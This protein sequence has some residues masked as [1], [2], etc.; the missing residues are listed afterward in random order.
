MGI[1]RVFIAR[2]RRLRTLPPVVAGQRWRYTGGLALLLWLALNVVAAE[3]KRV[4]MI[5]SFGATAPP[6]T[7]HSTAFEEELT[8]QAGQEVDLDEVSL[9]MA[10]YTAPDL[11]DAFA[12]FL[13]TRL[14]K[15]KPDLV[16]PIGSPA[17]RFVAQHRGRLFPQTSILYA[18]MD[19]RTLPPDALQTNAAF[20]GQVFDIVRL[21]EDILQL[22][23]D[24]TNL[25][26]VVG[27]SPLEQFWADM[28]RHGFEPFTNRVSLLFLNGLSFDQMRDR[29]ATL[30]P[31]S[32]I[33]L[34]LLVRDVTGVTI[35]EDEALQ[36]LRAVANAPINGIFR[37]QLGL[38]IVGGRL[39]DAEKIGR[40]AAGVGVRILRGEP[41]SSFPVQLEPPGPPEYDWR[42]L[43]RW[44]IPESRLPGGSL[45]RFREPTFWQRYQWRIVAV[46]SLCLFEAALIVL[47]LV[48]RASR[49]RATRA[50][51]ESEA[52][53]SLLAN[54]A[55]VLVW[56]AGPD[57]RCTFFNRPWLEFTG[58]ALEQE[59][60][61]GWAEGV[62]AEDVAACLKTFH[63][64]FD[65]RRPFI[66]EYRL[67]RHDGEYRWV[68]DHGVPRFDSERNFL[69]YIGSCADVTDRRRAEAEIQH[70][71]AELAHVGRISTLGA[72]AGTLAHELNQPLNAILNNAQA[73]S[74]FLTGAPPDLA[75]V[76]GALEDIAE[77]TR[78]AGEVI[79]QMR[80]LVKKD[81]PKFQSLDLNQLLE[82]VVQLLHADSLVRKVRL[83]LKLAPDLPAAQ[84]DNV[85]I[86]QVVLNLL[87]NAF[88]AM[89]DAPESERAVILR[90]R[91]P[92]AAV[93]Q[94]EVADHGTG[95]SPERLA[96]LFEP[97][98]S[99]KREG[100]GLGL[101]ISHSIILA[102]QGRLWAENNP[103]GGA[104][105][106]FTLPVR[107][108][109][110][111]PG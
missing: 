19:L 78:R 108:P 109:A 16:V 40:D 60:G 21:G 66:M 80:A 39:Y 97:F 67:R 7:V 92:E 101:S 96:N 69:G 61:D 5:H 14:A 30:P 107:E 79:R 68:T 83:E 22:A 95:L 81:E 37:N 59:L 75:E 3:P 18:G 33:F 52:R 87:L 102:H 106:H 50:L 36:N 17:G 54:T 31:H 46:V 20:V 29:V 104:T 45:V 1:A 62:H 82:K 56:V 64:A 43:R 77:D 26:I 70:Q 86:Q 88:D 89:K 8:R 23:P 85:Q 100:L 25:V 12:E 35:N 65:A 103:G 93:I 44:R 24:T 84:G 42:E 10:R 58:R 11:Q 99:S 110:L 34:G 53:F 6:F 63:E 98:R 74:R 48:N 71:R 91:Q 47:L 49:H 13:S 90:T 51:R 94:V 57:K 73:G 15:W 41:A 28:F 38:G 105:F 4:L 72:M 27:S 55:P 32:F 2:N 9:D 76:R 111:K